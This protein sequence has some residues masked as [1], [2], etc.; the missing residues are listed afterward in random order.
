MQLL[1]RY[2]VEASGCTR[3]HELDLVHIDDALG[4]ARPML[5]RDAT[6]SL[7]ILVVGEAPNWSDTYDNTK[8][9]LTYD[10]DTDPTGRFMFQLLTDEAGLT[11]SELGDVL[12]TNAVLCLPRRKRDRYPVS[13]AQLG[14][15][16]PWL[17]RLIVEM[18]VKVVVSMGARPLA[19]LDRVHRHGLTLK[20]AG[21]LHEWYGRKLLPLY[22]AG[23][24]GRISRPEAE[25]R[26]DIRA[27][28]RHL[29][30]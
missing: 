14:R 26:K 30:R 16:R 29:G 23:L 2:H 10:R 9:H 28:R 12:F 7:G 22:H 6:G 13:A 15:C 18:D 27:L 11:E 3:C 24:L 21:R 4:T 17:V 20:D 5:Q 19:A 25:Q 8:G 1:R